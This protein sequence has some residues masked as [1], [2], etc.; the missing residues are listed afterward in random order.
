[1]FEDLTLIELVKTGGVAVAVLVIFSIISLA[2]ILE[3]V[4]AFYRFKSALARTSSEL[5]LRIKD[6]GTAS[7]A[8]WCMGRTGRSWTGALAKVFL[9]G[10]LKRDKGRDEVLGA[11]ELSGRH[12]IAG[13]ERGLGVLGTIGSIAPFVGLFGTVIG[14]IRA[15]SDLAEETG[16]GPS[17]VAAGVSEAL[18]ATAAG[19]FVAIPAVIAYNFFVRS[20][21]RQTLELETLAAEF[22]ESL[23]LGPE[24]KE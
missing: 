13:L 6:G 9:A 22:I 12:E 19:L 8:D 5:R 20:V 1:M 14:I 17:V 23:G 16:G 18:V 11:M 15:F 10:Y 21:R 7:A 3:R 2:V 24:K 4:W